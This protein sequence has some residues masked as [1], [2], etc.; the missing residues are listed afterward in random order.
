M[1]ESKNI[2]HK[3]KK[4]PAPTEAGTGLQSLFKFWILGCACDLAVR[5]KN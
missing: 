1:G 2:K 4:K 3:S 5:P